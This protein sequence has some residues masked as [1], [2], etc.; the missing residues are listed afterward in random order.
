MSNIAQLSVKILAPIMNF[1]PQIVLL[2]RPLVTPPRASSTDQNRCTL[3]AVKH[4][5]LSIER[6]YN[7]REM[8]AMI[9][10]NWI[11]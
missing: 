9:R 11:T 3:K 4:E 8:I 1:T 5:I 7:S 2:S 6:K 10:S